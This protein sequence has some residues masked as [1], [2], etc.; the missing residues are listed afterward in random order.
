[1]ALGNMQHDR[2]RLEQGQIAFLE[3]RNL[4]ERLKR[5][6][7][8]VFHGRERNETDLLGLAHSLQRP[9]KAR[10]Q[11][12]GPCGVGRKRF[13]VNSVLPGPVKGGHSEMTLKRQIDSGLA[14]SLVTVGTNGDQP[15]GIDLKLKRKEPGFSFPL[16][17][18]A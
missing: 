10:G 6:M 2:P 11:G 12:E 1:M 15:P 3:G 13:V 14:R 17:L 16:K 9:A 18:R 5:Q 7:R 4:A 8:G